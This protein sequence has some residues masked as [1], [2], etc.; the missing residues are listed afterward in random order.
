MPYLEINT[1]LSLNDAEKQDL[2]GEIGKLIPLIPGKKKEITLIN[3]SG[4]LYI[5]LSEDPCINIE[6][7]IGGRTPFNCKR[8][9]V[10]DV[11]AML[12]EKYGFKPNR[13]FINIF[14][15]ENWGAFGKYTDN[16]IIDAD[17]YD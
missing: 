12:G 14:E 8:D 9:F 2:C 16:M 15:C 7:R 10:R 4:G 17:L 6:F 5:E 1:S 13:V 3:V 11:T